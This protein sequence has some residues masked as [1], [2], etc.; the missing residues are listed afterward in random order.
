MILVSLFTLLAFAENKEVQIT[1]GIITDSQPGDIACYLTIQAK[2]G[3]KHHPMAD[4]D[5]CS[6]IYIDKHATFSWQKVNVLADDCEGDVDCGR[7]KSEWIISGAQVKWS[8]SIKDNEDGTSVLHVQSGKH[9][10][11]IAVP[12][13]GCVREEKA[14]DGIFWKRACYFAGAG[15]SI[16]LK[17]THAKGLQALLSIDEEKETIKSVLWIEPKQAPEAP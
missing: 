3:T 12:L 14:D 2:D 13:G 15:G 7:S 1:E 4:F 6:S 8:A 9:S 11:K 5:L 10:H 17:Q 16:S